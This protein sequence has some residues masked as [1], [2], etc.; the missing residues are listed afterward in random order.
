MGPR[1][2]TLRYEVLGERR[3]DTVSAMVYLAL[4]LRR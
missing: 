2:L 1:A 4:M 3:P